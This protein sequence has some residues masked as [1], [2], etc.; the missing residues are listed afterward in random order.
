MA[1]S[2]DKSS[3]LSSHLP[4]PRITELLLRLLVSSQAV[5]QPA[6]GR[7]EGRARGGCAGPGRGGQLA[8]VAQFV[9]RQFNTKRLSYHHV[10]TQ[11]MCPTLCMDLWHVYSWTNGC[12]KLEYVPSLGGN[13]TYSIKDSYLIFIRVGQWQ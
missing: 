10:N 5:L 4:S 6:V 12:G 9:L 3:S 7:Q 8:G 1:R 13:I 11:R 2:L